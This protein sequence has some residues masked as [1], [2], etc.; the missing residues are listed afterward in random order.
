MIQW[1]RFRPSLARS[2]GS[3]PAWGTRTLQAVRHGPKIQPN[4]QQQQKKKGYYLNNKETSCQAMG[5][6]TE[7]E[8][9][10]LK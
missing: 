9:H 10:T 6:R 7:P 8:V 4:E 2:E 5:R 1:L 3:I